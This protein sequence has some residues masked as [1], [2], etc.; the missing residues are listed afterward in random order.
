M[1]AICN[2][3]AYDGIFRPSG[4]TFCVFADYMRRS[5]RLAALAK[6]P[7]DLHLHPRLGRRRRG[8][9]DP[10]AGGDRQRPARDPE[11]RRHPPRRPG[12]DRR[13]LGRRDGAHRRPDR[14]FSSP[15]RMC[16]TRSRSQSLT[17]REGA[18]RGA[19][20]RREGNRRPRHHPHRHRQRTAARCRGR[21]RARRRLP[22]RLACPAWN[23][24]TA[25][26]PTTA[27]RSCP[28]AC[29]KRIAIEAGVSRHLVE[30]C[31][32]R[33]QSHRH[34]PLRH[35]RPCRAGIR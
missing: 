15:A 27:T 2:G 12:G 7:V 9:P 4:A 6:L 17:R 21:R 19:L 26:P 25:R 16:Q 3:I 28:P 34:R 23:A 11:P 18:F 8:R 32:Q 24:S 35:Q 33:G 31:R 5:I 22:R 1:G 10:P 14:C 20:H 30:V 13:R 29:T